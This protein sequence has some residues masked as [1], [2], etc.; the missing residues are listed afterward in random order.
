MSELSMGEFRRL[1]KAK[2]DELSSSISNRD[3]IMIEAT[4]DEMDRLQAQMGRDIA[5]RN[6]DRTSSLLKS[7]RAALERIDDEAYG[8]CLHCEEPIAAKRLKAVPWATYCVTCQ[9]MVDRRQA[10]NNDD[11]EASAFAA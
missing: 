3:S 11:V 2:Y 7:I 8:V 4:A 6:L 10:S 1:L 5:V 9:E